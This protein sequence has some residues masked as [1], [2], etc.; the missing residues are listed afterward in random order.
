MESVVVARFDQLEPAVAYGVWRLRQEVFMLEQQCLYPDLDG[1]DLEPGTLHV[2][3]AEGVAEGSEADP[4]AVRGY[5]RILDED[6]REWRI[7]RVVAAPPARGSGLAHRVVTAAVGA[8]D[9]RGPRPI[10]LDA[11]SPLVP[12]YAQHGFD[13]DGAE[14]L[15]DGIAHTP[16]RRIVPT[17]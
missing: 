16:M 2:V 14:F 9:E 4:P 10:V 8:C 6:G 1:R 5:C 11:Q 3:V 7:G 13:V 17:P 15:E 12:W